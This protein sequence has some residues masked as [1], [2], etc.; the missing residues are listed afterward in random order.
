[1]D[2]E[3][4]LAAAVVFFY[5]IRKEEKL[6]KIEKKRSTWTKPWLTRRDALAFYNTL[7]FTMLHNNLQCPINTFLPSK[8]K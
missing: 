5:I 8:C 3:E 6:K 1:M 4:E 7:Q 2:S